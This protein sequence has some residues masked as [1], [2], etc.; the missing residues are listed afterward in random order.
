MTAEALGPVVTVTTWLPDDERYIARPLSAS[1]ARAGSDVTQV[2]LPVIRRREL[3]PRG[4][5]RLLRRMWLLR[6]RL[7]ARSD[8]TV[9]VSTSAL[10]PVLLAV[11]RRVRVVVH[12]HETWGP[13]TRLVLGPFLIRA[14]VVLAPSRAVVE[15]LPA[16][17]R[18]K[19]FVIPNGTPDPASDPSPVA[20]AGP[21]TFV[22]ASRWGAW[23]GHRLL[24]EAWGRLQRTDVK[25]IILGGMPPTGSGVN[26][27]AM[28]ADLPNAST[29]EVV[30][31]VNDI[32]PFIEAAHGVILPSS[33]PEPFGLVAIEG[34][35]RG[36]AVIASAAGGCLEIVDEGSGWLL[37]VGDVNAWAVLLET[38]TRADLTDKGNAGRLR[39]EEMYSADSFGRQIR[40]VVLGVD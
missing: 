10:A 11:P 37:P 4:I 12:V 26:V 19:A 5:A 18:G 7:A 3:N 22:V 34:M 8:E 20:H 39:Y 38:V 33:A 21:V 9:L 27:P 40:R 32:G 35:A 25:L 16:F 24:L 31:E 2:S 29:V 36:R 28:V 6:K 14:A 17:V 30:G 1:L 13:L 15:R 23:K